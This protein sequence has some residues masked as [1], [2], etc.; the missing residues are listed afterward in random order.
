LR[1]FASALQSLFVDFVT[2]YKLTEISLTATKRREEL[3]KEGL[4]MIESY[5]KELEELEYERQTRL[6]QKNAKS[7]VVKGNNKRGISCRKNEREDI[8]TTGKN[9]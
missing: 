8:K 2:F 6:Q 7:N 5:E 1:V 4:K 3:R 9:S